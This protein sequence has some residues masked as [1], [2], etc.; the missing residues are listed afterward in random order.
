MN[1]AGEFNFS[2]AGFFLPVGFTHGWYLATAMRFCI[3]YWFNEGYHQW[4]DPVTALRFSAAFQARG[5]LQTLFGWLAL[6]PD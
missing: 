3:N 4:L 1:P 5:V 2:S 6:S